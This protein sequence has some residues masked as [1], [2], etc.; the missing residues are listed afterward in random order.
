MIEGPRVR[1]KDKIGPTTKMLKGSRKGIFSSKR[2]PLRSS[3][4]KDHNFD[5][6]IAK[7]KTEIENISED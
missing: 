5:D 2:V 3:I 6:E 1:F 7:V 4:M